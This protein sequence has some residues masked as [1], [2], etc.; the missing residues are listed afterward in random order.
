MSFIENTKTF[1]R[2]VILIV[3]VLCLSVFQGVYAPEVRA[4]EVERRVISVSG[5]FTIYVKPDVATVSFGVETNASTAQEAQAENSSLMNKVISELLAQGIS[6]E[7]IQTSDFALYPVYETIENARTSQQMLIGYRCNNTVT[8]RIK[9]LSKIGQIIDATVKAGATN[10]GGISFGVLDPKKYQDQVLA[11]AVE[12]ARHKA[13]VM[14][15]AAGVTIKDVINI[16]DGWVSV[17][18]VRKTANF[19]EAQ[20]DETPIE[21]GEVTITATVRMDFTF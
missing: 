6:R 11:K 12:H 20:M 9:D 7:D 4:E 13:E 17:S 21:P 14:A 16:S 2:I 5:E 1:R 3:V 10:V 8:V 18:S 19:A 15:K